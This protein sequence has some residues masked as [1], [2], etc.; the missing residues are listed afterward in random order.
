MKRADFVT[1]LLDK[2]LEPYL[3]YLEQVKDKDKDLPHQPGAGF[4]SLSM[5]QRT[6]F[7]NFHSV[8]TGEARCASLANNEQVSVDKPSMDNI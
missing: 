3:T 7:N 2:Y 5:L 6:G 4:G 1:E 8:H